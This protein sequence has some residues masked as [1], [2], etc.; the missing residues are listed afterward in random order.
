MKII[1]RADVENLG[2]LG[3]VVTVRPGYG[4]NYLLPQG[5]AMAATPGNIKVFELERRKLQAR[6][7]ALRAEADALFAK[8]DGITLVIPMRVGDNDKLYGSVTSHII[9]DALLE[10]G[11]EVDRR[12]ILFDHAIRTLGEH[13]VRIRLHAD[14]VATMT[15]KVVSEDK[16]HPEAEEAAEAETAAE[17]DAVEQPSA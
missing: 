5:L 16:Y 3:D 8:L 10:K 15:V 6:M 13:P 7:D 1:L 14:V 12:R 4:R 17:A 11:M 2:R 9:G